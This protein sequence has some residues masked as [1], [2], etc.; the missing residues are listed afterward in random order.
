M[1]ELAVGIVTANAT[2]AGVPVKYVLI[3]EIVYDASVAVE[4][5]SGV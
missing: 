5:T 2:A 1:F 4:T 3:L